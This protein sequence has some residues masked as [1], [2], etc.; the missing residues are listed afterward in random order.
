MNQEFMR[1][2][3]Q[4]LERVPWVDARLVE[5]TFPESF[6]GVDGFFMGADLMRFEGSSETFDYQARRVGSIEAWTAQLIHEQ[7]GYYDEGN[8]WITA[9]PYGLALH[10]VSDLVL[11]ALGLGEE[12]QIDEEFSC[13][14][15]DGH[16]ADAL[17]SPAFL[18]G[19]MRGVG[20]DAAATVLKRCADGMAP[21]DAWALAGQN[22][23]TS[24]LQKLAGVLE[25]APH[26]GVAAWDEPTPFWSSH[27]LDKLTHFS[28]F[29]RYHPSV[30]PDGAWCGDLAMWAW[31][32]YG[33]D[34]EAYFGK[35]ANVGLAASIM[36]G[37]TPFEGS[38][39][40]EA[41]VSPGARHG[42]DELAFCLG[43][44]PDLAA[45]AVQGVA[46]GVFPS[47]MW[48]HLQ[49][50][51]GLDDWVEKVLGHG[52]A[53]GNDFSPNGDKAIEDGGMQDDK[54]D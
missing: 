51:V 45:D 37:L 35:E 15:L 48:T 38:A 54:D 23:R 34:A 41:H 19:R 7:G 2:L 9:K 10:E 13:L 31:K 14:V 26:A 4:R 32:L 44:T 28:M 40:F 16:V 53:D 39:L 12:E 50:E 8:S 20:S 49:D 6:Q 21:Q 5:C 47:F 27:D 24:R 46:E 25:T 30:M 11:L 17:L 18:H 1:L 33:A 3:A 29:S 43:L 52:I 36:L 42:F 22:L